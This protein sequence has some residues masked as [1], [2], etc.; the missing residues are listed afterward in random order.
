M[1]RREIKSEGRDVAAAIIR[2]LNE[3]GRRR[4]QVEVTVIQE[5]KAGFLGIGGRPAIVHIIEKKW[6]SEHS[7]VRGR[8]RDKSP[9]MDEKEP[10]KKRVNGNKEDKKP[11]GNRKERGGK[12]SSAALRPAR[13]N[14][15]PKASKE[16]EAQRL[17]SAQIQNAVIPAEMTEP[18]AKA[19]ESLSK[20]LEHMC[21]KAENMQV[22]WDAQQQRILLT[23]D[24]DHPAVV[25]GKEGKTL[26]SIQ[27]LITLMV[28]RDFENPISVIADTQNYWRKLEDKIDEEISKAVK[29]LK[30]TRRPYKF[31]PMP[32]Q[33]RRYV[34]RYFNEGSGIS[35]ASEGE[36]RFRRIVLRLEG[37]GSNYTPA[38]ESGNSDAGGREVA[39]SKADLTPIN[40]DELRKDNIA[41]SAD[42]DDKSG[43]ISPDNANENCVLTAETT[44]C[45]DIANIPPADTNTNGDGQK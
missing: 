13:A 23:F 17:P 30:R 19:K 15:A 11:R 8:M 36:G 38:P 29:M 32:A 34:H 31:R 6:D 5:E 2:G 12:S 37:K 18:L 39:R 28:S 27:Y 33:V 25:I 20:I 45:E 10:S 35:T 7:P 9:Y 41:N 1:A 21:V 14:E 22:W 24:C 16:N 40:W 26:E 44:T 3:L 42:L 4:D 43:V